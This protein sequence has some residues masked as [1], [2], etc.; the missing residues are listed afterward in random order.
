[1]NLKHKKCDKGIKTTFNKHTAPIWTVQ[2]GIT[3]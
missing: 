2:N 3:Q 1:M